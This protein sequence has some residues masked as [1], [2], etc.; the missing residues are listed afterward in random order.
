MALAA[1]DVS[2]APPILQGRQ[3]SST[4]LQNHLNTCQQD[5]HTCAHCWFAAGVMA[6]FHLMV[7]AFA[8]WAV[9][10]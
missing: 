7:V 5:H 10:C 1:A 2:D 8:F 6:I 4:E 9:E 3:Q